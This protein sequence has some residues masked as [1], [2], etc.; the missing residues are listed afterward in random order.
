MLNS[1]EELCIMRA[2]ADNS[3]ARVLNPHGRAYSE[4]VFYDNAPRLLI[5]ISLINHHQGIYD[6]GSML[7]LKNSFISKNFKKPEKFYASLQ[8]KPTSL[9]CSNFNILDFKTYND[10]N[11][12]VK[13]NLEVKHA[14]HSNRHCKQHRKIGESRI[15]SNQNAIRRFFSTFFF[16]VY[17]EI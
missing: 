2:A 1:F 16:Y 4:E 17:F 12:Q 11:A 3:F 7:P 14:F 15:I 6:R 10:W 5:S 9:Q 8:I 13:Y